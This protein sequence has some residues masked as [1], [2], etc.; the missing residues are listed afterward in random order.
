MDSRCSEIGP[1]I[2]ESTR[3][4]YPIQVLSFVLELQSKLLQALFSFIV[5]KT[6][7][8]SEVILRDCLKVLRN[9]LV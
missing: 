3:D 5:K 8:M 4:L 9:F 1:N 2:R 6:C 7:Q